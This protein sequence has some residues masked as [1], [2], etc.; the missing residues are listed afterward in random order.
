MD[1]GAFPRNYTKQIYQNTAPGD[2]FRLLWIDFYKGKVG[3][4]VF[5]EEV[6][7]GEQDPNFLEDF[8]VSLVRNQDDFDKDNPLY[9]VNPTCY[10]SWDDVTR[11]VFSSICFSQLSLREPLAGSRLFIFKDVRYR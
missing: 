8:S 2:S 11:Y 10:H 5:Q 9:L 3:G 4:D 6:H 7:S 1:V